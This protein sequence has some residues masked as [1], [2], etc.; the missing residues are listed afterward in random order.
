MTR[1]LTGTD[2]YDDAVPPAAPAVAVPGGSSA[3]A[4]VAAAAASA[5]KAAEETHATP[6]PRLCSGYN[7]ALP[8]KS[9]RAA[10]RNEA[11]FLC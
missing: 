8:R 7:V 6:H 5:P 3:A 9:S 11:H 4:A 10:I 1:P 2:D